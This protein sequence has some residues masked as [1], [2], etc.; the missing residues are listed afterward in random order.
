MSSDY[1]FLLPLLVIIVTAAI[2]AG[3]ILVKRKLKAIALKSGSLDD[4]ISEAGYS[5]DPRQ[6]IFY[7]NMNAWQRDMGYCR[8]YDEAAGSLSM[9]FDSEPITFDYDGREWLIEFWK[10]QYGMTSGAEIGVYSREKAENNPTEFLT[11]P[12]YDC[13]A[14]DDRLLMSFYLIKNGDV[15]IDRMERHWWLTGFKLGTFSEPEELTMIIEITLKNTEM[16]NAFIQGLL[17]AGYDRNEIFLNG[18]TI[19]LQF[20]TPKTAQ[21]YTRIKSIEELTQKKNK[22]LCEKYMELTKDYKTFPE[23][24]NALKEKEPELYLA[25]INLGKTKELFNMVNK[26]RVSK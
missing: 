12:F 19:G 24:V 26:L 25:L 15:L 10:G 17:K 18:N 20:D 6:D 8:L 7:S 3:L 5:Y 16:Q 23:K 2:A 1:S 21:P 11:G 9:I 4:I 14:D 13:A 22:L